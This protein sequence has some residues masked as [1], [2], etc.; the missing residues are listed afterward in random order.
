MLKKY[1]HTPLSESATAY[2]SHTHF[3][4]PFCL[5]QRISEKYW[6]VFQLFHFSAIFLYISLHFNSSRT[7]FNT[8][9]K[10]FD[11]FSR[12]KQKCVFFS[13]NQWENIWLLIGFF[14]FSRKHASF[15]QFLAYEYIFAT[16]K[17][18]YVWIAFQ[19]VLKLWLR[20]FVGYFFC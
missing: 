4:C 10:I 3:G 9:F 15:S 1:I 7:I 18:R 12:G 13:S 17:C 11:C 20:I 19:A 16:T 8:T 6:F 2:N 5:N 14:L